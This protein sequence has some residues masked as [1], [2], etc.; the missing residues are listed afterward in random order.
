MPQVFPLSIPL[1]DTGALSSI[2]HESRV[3]TLF[4][5]LSL[6]FSS[7]LLSL[8]IAAVEAFD[9]LLLGQRVPAFPSNPPKEACMTRKVMLVVVAVAALLILTSSTANAQTPM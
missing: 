1:A 7:S 6:A 5:S 9:P 3:P 8:V 4:L 2:L